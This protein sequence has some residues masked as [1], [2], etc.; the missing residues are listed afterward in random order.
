MS[1]VR[2]YHVPSLTKKE[3]NKSAFDDVVDIKTK[4]NRALKKVRHFDENIGEWMIPADA[5][6]KDLLEVRVQ[7][8]GKL[9]ELQENLANPA[10]SDHRRDTSTA[11]IAYLEGELLPQMDY[12]GIQE[13]EQPAAKPAARPDRFASRLPVTVPAKKKAHA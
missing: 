13:Q 10:T 7:A 12:F 9:G 8:E 11:G 6:L 5:D 3:G 2:T 1:N 4:Y